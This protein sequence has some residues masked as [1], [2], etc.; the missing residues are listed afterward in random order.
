[1]ASLSIS[2][3]VRWVHRWYD[4]SGR[5]KPDEVCQ[6]LATLALN[7]VCY[8]PGAADPSRGETLADAELKDRPVAPLKKKITPRAKR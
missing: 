5:L 1:L 6:K 4:P 8:T 3:M 7:S 2:G